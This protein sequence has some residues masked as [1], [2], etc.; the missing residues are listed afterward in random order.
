VVMRA[1]PYC[2]HYFLKRLAAIGRGMNDVAFRPHAIQS[3]ME[4]MLAAAALPM[5]SD[6]QIR[7]QVCVHL[8]TILFLFL[9]L[10]CF[11]M[12]L[13]LCLRAAAALPMLPDVQIRV[14]VRI[15]LTIFI[16]FLH[17]FVRLLTFVQQGSAST[18]HVVR[19]ADLH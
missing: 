17:T 9:V 15:Y 14:Q 16:L 7:V 8:T 5:L 1:G 3:V 11:V 19:S 2:N 6:V 10:Q 12:F 13:H 4:R 18:A